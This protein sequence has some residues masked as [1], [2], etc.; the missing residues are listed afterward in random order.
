MTETGNQDIENCSSK[1]CTRSCISKNSAQTTEGVEI[2][3]ETIK[4]LKGDAALLVCT[5]SAIADRRSP[6]NKESPKLP[7]DF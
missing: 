4:V 2:M 1:L 6:R 3:Q 5:A 7:R